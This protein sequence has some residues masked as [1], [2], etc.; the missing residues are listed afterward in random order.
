MKIQKDYEE[1]LE[2]L[3]KHGARYCVIGSFALAFHARPRYTKDMDILVQPTGDNANAVLKA[4]RDFGFESP[5]L[6][7]DDFLDPEKVIQIGYEPVRIDLL[8]SIPG[9]SF[10]DAW[11]SRVTARYGSVDAFFIG[12]QALIESK[13]ASGRKQDLA[14]LEL[15]EE[16]R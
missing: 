6:T 5:E 7:K 2:L 13:R 9:C 4:L 11:E 14:D 3:N 12:K 16:S 15:L 8:T 10:D 1:F